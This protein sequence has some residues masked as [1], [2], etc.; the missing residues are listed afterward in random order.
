MRNINLKTVGIKI[1]GMWCIV[2]I[3][4]NRTPDN[5]LQPPLH[6]QID[7]NISVNFIKITK[8]GNW[9]YR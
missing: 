2:T 1:E 3:A 7:E 5:V 6:L 4:G 8:K 9:L